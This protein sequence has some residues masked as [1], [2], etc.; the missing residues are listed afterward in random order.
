M[1][2]VGVVLLIAC[3][4]VAGLMT[5]RAAARQR[6]TAIRLSLG[7]GRLRIVRQCLSESLVLAMVGCGL[8]IVGAG[9]LFEALVEYAGPKGNV[10]EWQLDMRMMLFTALVTVAAAVLSGL[11]PALQS[12]RANTAETLKNQALSVAGGRSTASVRKGLVGAQVALATVL[13]ILAG[14]FSRSLWN[15]TRID[16]GFR[17]DAVTT[18]NIDLRAAGYDKVRR[19]ETY[20]VLAERLA[21]LPGVPAAS[22]ATPGPLSGSSNGGSVGVQGYVPKE[23][24][25]TGASR[26]WTMPG[27]F[28][29]LEIPMLAG[30]DFRYSDRYGSPKVA[31]VNEAFVRK[32]V[33]DG[34]ALGRKLGFALGA[35]VDIEII[36]V[37]AD[38]RTRSL[39][40]EQTPAVYVPYAQSADGPALTFYVRG[41]TGPSIR[42]VVNALDP[43]VP[44]YSI[45]TFQETVERTTT[46]ERLMT[47]LTACF[48]GLAVLLSAVGIY[49]VIAWTVARRTSE[50]AIRVALGAERAAVLKLML[51]E[52]LGVAGVGIAAGTAV[53][54]ATN[55]LVETQLFG[56]TGRDPLVILSAVAVTFGF[57]GLAALIPSW[58]AT[59]ID[60]AAALRSE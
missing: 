39:R 42:A 45:A 18:F 50:I 51:R 47:F 20:R 60:P 54:V 55:R 4:N 31:V 29:T 38:I 1:A 12:I 15:L 40:E 6:E 26:H 27:F 17:T 9:W 36:G 48:G 44:V 41:A 7:A 33:A 22:A 43:N 37:V 11:A 53:A 28:Q 30:R 56:L 57:A 34:N 5:A 58:R 49:G 52:V 21:Q 14:L 35:G 8:G 19:D 24:E 3:I 25:E 2:T 10:L 13:L 16:P 59:R 32:Y 23:G 46:S